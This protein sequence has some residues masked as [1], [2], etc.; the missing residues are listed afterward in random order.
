MNLRSSTTSKRN[1]TTFSNKMA[2]SVIHKCMTV[3]SPV[4][5]RYKESSTYQRWRNVTVRK[6]IK[7]GGTT[8]TQNVSYLW[9]PGVY[10]KHAITRKTGNSQMGRNMPPRLIWWNVTTK[11]QEGI[12]GPKSTDRTGIPS[13]SCLK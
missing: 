12:T 5:E 8:K 7:Y 13:I 1:I 3:R 4:R 9:V 2:K 11:C 10:V 6:N